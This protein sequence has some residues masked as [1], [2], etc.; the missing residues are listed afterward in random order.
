MLSK[1][2]GKEYARRLQNNTSN[3]FNKNYC[4]KAGVIFLS[5]AAGQTPPP[6]GF[7]LSFCDVDDMSTLF[8]GSLAIVWIAV[9]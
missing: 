1:G 9:T 5:L 7:L 8:P 3:A 4:W 2:S 6:Y